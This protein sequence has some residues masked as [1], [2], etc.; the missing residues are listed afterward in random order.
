MHTIHLTLSLD[1]ANLIL[2]ALGA[3]PYVRVHQLVQKIQQQAQAQLQ[4]AQA[5]PENGIASQITENE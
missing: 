4:Q 1:E 5:M 2:E 3:Q